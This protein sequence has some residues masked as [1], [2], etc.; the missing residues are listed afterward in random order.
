MLDAR[1]ALVTGPDRDG[2][3]SLKRPGFVHPDFYDVLPGARKNGKGWKLPANVVGTTDFIKPLNLVLTLSRSFTAELRPYQADAVVFCLSRPLGALLAA[4]V[5]LGKTRIASVCL[6]LRPTA[7]PVIVVGPLAAMNVWCG[8]DAD[9]AKIAGLRL[10]AIRGTRSDYPNDYIEALETSD[11]VFFNYE[12]LADWSTR[13][14]FEDFGAVIVDESHNIRNPRTKASDCLRRI[15]RSREMQLRLALS[16]TPIVNGVSDL[17]AQLDFAQPNLWGPWVGKRWASAGDNASFRQRYAGAV[18]TEYGWKDADEET[19]PEELRQ[20]LQQTV[21]KIDRFKVQHELPPF[22]RLVERVPAELLTDEYMAEYRN[23]SNNIIRY[24]KA[25][26]KATGGEMSPDTFKGI[27]LQQATAMASHLSKA[28]RA[29]A[30]VVAEEMLQQFGKVVVFTWYTDTARYIA[31]ELKKHGVHAV[32]GPVTGK[33]L[34]KK[35]DEA[36]LGFQSAKAETTEGG[37][38]AFVTLTSNPESNPNCEVVGKSGAA[39]VAT[40]A[41]CGVAM[42]ELSCA[43]AA[44]FVD[45]Y[46]VPA[47]LLQA[48]GRIHRQGQRANVCY[49]KY[50]L[51]ESSMD[52]LMYEHL[53]RKAATIERIADDPA[54]ASLC[55]TLGGDKATAKQDFEE[56]LKALATADFG[57]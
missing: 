47:V 51:V 6:A 45:L 40:L 10:H 33:L 5:G 29:H 28:K 52:D 24:I 27:P 25:R 20:R 37:A 13:L 2:F 49:A 8:P 53:L 23:A 44:L 46:W 43:P 26:V 11:G 15:S 17:W 55:E 30:V 7:R 12:L 4:D 36:A 41:T 1:G 9:P 32:F 56:L 31:K 19:Q 50:L 39:F 34:K 3:F 42:N 22:T 35:R 48:E 14:Q 38:N 18:Q 16:A 21:L 57:D 54:A